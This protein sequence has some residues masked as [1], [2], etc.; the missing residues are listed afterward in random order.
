MNRKL[1]SGIAA[2]LLCAP[3]LLAGEDAPAPMIINIAD[4][5]AV[6][7]DGQWK[8]LVDPYIR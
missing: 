2:V 3:A 6:S 7:L 4:R 8:Y 1:L 5:N